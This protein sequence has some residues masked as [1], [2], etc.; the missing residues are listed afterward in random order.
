[1]SKLEILF[2]LYVIWAQIKIWFVGFSIVAVLT[3]VDHH[4]RPLAGTTSVSHLFFWQKN[5]VVYD[6]CIVITL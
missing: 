5:V 3:V 6:R 2:I 1:M 4:R